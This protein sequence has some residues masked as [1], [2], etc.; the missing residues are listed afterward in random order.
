MDRN[1]EDNRE[2]DRSPL[3]EGE[4]NS[5]IREETNVRDSLADTK[6]GNNTPKV[7]PESDVFKDQP[8]DQS[9]R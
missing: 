9:E 2:R 5:E 6:I 7:T 8:T 1:R 3:D 4:R